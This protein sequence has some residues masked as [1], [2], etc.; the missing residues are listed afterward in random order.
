MGSVLSVTDLDL[1]A[2]GQDRIVEDEEDESEAEPT[3]NSAVELAPQV[4]AR[5]CRRLQMDR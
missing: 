3:V 5:P 4:C 1:P 2:H